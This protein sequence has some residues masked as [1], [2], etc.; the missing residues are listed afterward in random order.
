MKAKVSLLLI[1]LSTSE[2]GHSGV[3]SSWMASV[4]PWCPS[5]CENTRSVFV[6]TGGLHEGSFDY[7]VTGISS[8][9]M[10]H[11][12]MVRRNEPKITPNTN[13]FITDS[14]CFSG[15]SRPNQSLVYICGIRLRYTAIVLFK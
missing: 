6:V 2:D 10:G 4:T 8:R 7:S 14:V 11:L 12:H 13:S 9:A 15:L 1:Y 5:P 3:S